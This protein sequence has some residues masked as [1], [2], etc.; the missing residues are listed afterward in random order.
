MGITFR[1]FPLTFQTPKKN[2]THINVVLSV[3][4]TDQM[5][6]HVA[7]EC[8]GSHVGEVCLEF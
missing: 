2:P 1:L 6:W 8:Y 5:G 7:A 3:T 4:S